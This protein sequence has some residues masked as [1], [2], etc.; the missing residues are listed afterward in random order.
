MNIVTPL[1]AMSLGE[2]IAF[3]NVFHKQ[4][5]HEFFS[6]S[7]PGTLLSAFSRFCGVNKLE[8]FHEDLVSNREL[9]VTD[10]L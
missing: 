1:S 9:D 10:L 5:K 4:A 3:L 7:E 6:E 8:E 2:I